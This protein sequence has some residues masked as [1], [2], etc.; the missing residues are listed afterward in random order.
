MLQIS[1]ADSTGV[2]SG[3]LMLQIGLAYVT[4]CYGMLRNVTNE[5]ENQNHLRMR[6]KI[7]FNLLKRSDRRPA[8]PEIGG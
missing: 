6:M 1:M 4:K 7:I 3:W 2:P 8:G 5:N